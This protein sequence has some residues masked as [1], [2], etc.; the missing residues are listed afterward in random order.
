MQEHDR[1]PVAPD[2]LARCCP[3][4]CVLCGAPARF[5]CIYLPGPSSPIAPP[6]PLVRMV[7][8][9]LCGQCGQRRSQLLTAI[10]AVL[11]RGPVTAVR[12]TRHEP[13]RSRLR[14]TRTS[15]R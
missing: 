13:A 3:T 5:A 8:Y 2:W 14:K 1:V 7:P 4:T 15:H 12:V 9:G 10:E 6:K 11:E